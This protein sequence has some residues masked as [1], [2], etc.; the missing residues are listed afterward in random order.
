MGVEQ[1]KLSEAALAAA[2]SDELNVEPDVEEL[3]R[4]LDEGVDVN[5][6]SGVDDG[7]GL[8]LLQ[9]AAS[10]GVVDSVRLLLERG[11]D[12][13]CPSNAGDP[14]VTEVVAVQCAAEHGHAEILRML[15][16]AKGNLE[17]DEGDPLKRTA[18]GYACVGGKADIDV[19]AL[20]LAYGGSRDPSWHAEQRARWDDPRSFSV[21][22]V[23]SQA[24]GAVREALQNTLRGFDRELSDD[25]RQAR[26]S[27]QLD[28]SAWLE[29]TRDWYTPLFYLEHLSPVKTVSLL[30]EDGAQVD[31]RVMPGRL[32]PLDRARDL[33]LGPEDAPGYDTALLVMKAAGK[34]SP[35]THYLWPEA[36]R[37]RAV[38]LL[39]IVYQIASSQK[40]NQPSSR[41]LIENMMPHAMLT[42][43]TYEE[44][45]SVVKGLVKDARELEA[46]SRALG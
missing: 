24:E 12:V 38:S 44:A 23:T 34:W 42:R 33:L 25:E 1:S 27:M 5:E 40:E 19:V 26:Y 45:P 39:K 17:L 2:G 7:E 10:K 41:V 4:L 18:V 9:H 11:A 32:S 3:E 37:A 14:N 22:H 29:A 6:W 36:G 31:T 20:L 13:N 28:L 35:Q 8:T 43:G 15:L 46:A 16:E 21:P 30:S